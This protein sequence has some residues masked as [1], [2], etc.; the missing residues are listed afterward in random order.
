MPRFI[1]FVV[2]TL[3]FFSPAQA[4]KQGQGY[5]GIQYAL[6]EVDIDVSGLDDFEPTAL[7][8]KVGYFVNPNVAIEGRYGIGLQDD[9]QTYLGAD[10]ELDI[11]QIIGLY[12]V[13]QTSGSSAVDFYGILG[14]SDAEADIK[15][16]GSSDSDSEDGFSYGVGLNFS[17]FNAEYMVYLNEDDV[18]VS[19]IAVGYVGYF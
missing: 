2:L 13:F 8:G 11:D 9:D 3:M 5:F 4:A 12:A 1:L 7:V 19:A 10:V 18:E 6:T 17:G 15:I 14:Y 16:D